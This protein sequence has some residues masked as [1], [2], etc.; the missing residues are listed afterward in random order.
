MH[1]PA[2]RERFESMGF[3]PVGSTPDE[4]AELLKRQTVLWST[5]LKTVDLQRN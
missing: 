5:A 2:M 1:A 3:E 4:Y